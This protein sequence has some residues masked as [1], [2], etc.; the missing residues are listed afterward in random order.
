MFHSLVRANLNLKI[1]LIVSAWTIKIS[2]KFYK[3]RNSR[4]QFS[5]FFFSFW[6][7]FNFLPLS[8][9]FFTVSSVDK[10]RNSIGF[11]FANKATANLANKLLKFFSD[12]SR[13]SPRAHRL[14][15][16]FIDNSSNDDDAMGEQQQQQQ[17]QQYANDLPANICRNVSATR[18]RCNDT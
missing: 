13:L 5:F 8:L 15:L 12:L 9:V 7:V 10:R 3:S 2:Y 16:A 1:F 4:W 11:D 17:K 18:G 6:F 14:C